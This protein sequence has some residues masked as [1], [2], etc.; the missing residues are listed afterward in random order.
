MRNIPLLTGHK[1]AMTRRIEVLPEP[2]S[3]QMN[4]IFFFHKYRQFIRYILLHEKC[5]P[6][7]T[8]WTNNDSID[9]SFETMRESYSRKKSEE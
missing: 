8:V 7:I 6:V 1:P 2:M 9:A 3:D 5:I 4:T